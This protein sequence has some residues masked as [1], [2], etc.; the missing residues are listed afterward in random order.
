MKEFTTENIGS[1]H[2][3]FHK[4]AGEPFTQVIVWRND[5]EFKIPVAIFFGPHAKLRANEYAAILNK[6]GQSP[7]DE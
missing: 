6:N 2:K 3:Y 4:P 5:E 1:M 7:G